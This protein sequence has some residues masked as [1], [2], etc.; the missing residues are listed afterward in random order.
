MARILV[1]GCGNI[2]A[3]LAEKLALGGHQVTGLKRR[4]EASTLSVSV[5]KA[6]LSELNDLLALDFDYDQLIYIVAP[7]ARGLDAYQA[8]FGTGLDNVL[9]V[10]AEKNPTLA[11]T[12]VSSTRVYGQQH[13]EWLTE[14]S[15][16]APD[17][18]RGKIILAA[19]NRVLSFNQQSM[20]VRFSGIYGRSNDLLGKLKAGAIIQKEPA[21]YTNRIHRDD[22]IGVLDFLIN[23]KLKKERMKRLY[24][25][26]DDEPVTQW[27]LASYLCGRFNYPQPIAQPLNKQAMSNKRL[28]NSA[29]KEAGYRFKFNSY[30]DGYSEQ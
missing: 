12:F 6:D 11:V 4:P 26:T 28:D 30:K 13:G 16:A 25:A 14:E 17:D 19:E 22:C 7:S 18:E 5:I 15:I 8:I 1:V 29:L 21:Y 10:L 24:L 27:D 3:A 2:G 9:T 23:K 20:V